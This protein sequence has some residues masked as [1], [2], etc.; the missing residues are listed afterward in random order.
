MPER[1]VQQNKGS[2]KRCFH[3][4][5]RVS[6]IPTLQGPP[7]KI[8]TRPISKETAQ[9]DGIDLPSPTA[10]HPPATKI[11]KHSHSPNSNSRTPP[12]IADTRNSPER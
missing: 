1:S 12:N 10:F 5:A 4:L 2:N 8:T 3:S 9:Y 7:Y 6:R 11:E